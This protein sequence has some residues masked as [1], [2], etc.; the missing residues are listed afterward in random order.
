MALKIRLSRG[1]A[2]KRPFYKIVVAEALSPRD[3][4]FIERLGS[5]NPMVAK[6][7]AERLVLDVERVKY[8]ISK[9]AQPTLR[10]AKMLSSDGLVKAPVIRDQPIKSAPGKKRKEREAEAA[11]KLASAA[12]AAPAAEGPAEEATAAEATAEEET[13]EETTAGEEQTAEERE[14]EARKGK[15]QQREEQEEEKERGRNKQVNRR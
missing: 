12:E 1:G 2:K 13:T 3:G 15:R 9:G 14:A 8:W 7:H 11:E 10:V 6:D 5:Y 4:K